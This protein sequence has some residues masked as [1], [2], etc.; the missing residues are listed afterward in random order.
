MSG[1][2]R[3]IFRALAAAALLAGC[4]AGLGPSGIYTLQDHAVSSVGV[5]ATAVSSLSLS[6]GPPMAMGV[7]AEVAQPDHWGRWQVL[8]LS[9]VSFVPRPDQ[10]RV[11][12]EGL[13]SLG[14]AHTRD[15]AEPRLYPVMGMELGLPLRLSDSKPSWRAD[16]LVGFDWF[17]VPSASATWLT[18]GTL[19]L[20]ASLMLRLNLWSGLQP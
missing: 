12:F 6:G 15:G 1:H 14:L 5:R 3:G 9:G 10:P 11:G 16:D 13:T 8:A 4:S 19:E 18:S 7:E 17:L 20:S 2:G